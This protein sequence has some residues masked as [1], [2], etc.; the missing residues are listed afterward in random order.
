M[1]PT[2]NHFVK[3]NFRIRLR[4]DSGCPSPSSS[5]FDD[6]PCKGGLIKPSAKLASL[7]F[8]HYRSSEHTQ[9][10]FDTTAP[11]ISREKKIDNCT[12]H[13]TE[14]DIYQ[15]VAMLQNEIATLKSE[16]ERLRTTIKDQADRHEA[17]KEQ[18]SAQYEALLTHVTA[19]YEAARQDDAAQYEAATKKQAAEFEAMKEENAA[20]YKAAKENAA[21]YEAI[22]REE[23]AR[24]EAARK[25]DA[26]RFEAARKQDEAA[27]RQEFIRFEAAPKKDA[28]H[29]EAITK[30]IE[31]V[32]KQSEAVTKQSEPITKQSD[33]VRTQEA[34]HYEFAQNETVEKQNEF[35][36]NREVAH[37]EVAMKR[38]E[39]ARKKE[40]TKKM[41][42]DDITLRP[43]LSPRDAV[44]KVRKGLRAE[45]KEIC[46]EWE[47]A[48]TEYA[49]YDPSKGRRVGKE[50]KAR[51]HQLLENKE[52]K[53]DQIYD[54]EDAVIAL[55]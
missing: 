7:G 11:I 47:K 24:Y 31:A 14:V 6:T 43:V 5:T 17:E 36:R 46:R 15:N 26:A 19:K 16:N 8:G 27:W 21:N 44:E 32:T 39:F 23:I 53:G 35:T 12:N 13:T 4:A 42:E 54:F 40:A 10:T 52:K 38:N 50:L 22:R 30:Q 18:E 3:R 37:Y 45:Y 28:T 25:E 33:A 48:N 9:N 34:V 51:I 49:E 41:R 55:N 2:S 1:S 20:R 29:H